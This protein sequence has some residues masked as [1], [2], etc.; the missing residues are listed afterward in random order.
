MTDALPGR[1]SQQVAARLLPWLLLL[2][3]LASLAHF[4]HNAE[5]L[6]D[7]PNLPRSWSP[8]EVY[9]AW[10]AVSAVG[11]GGYLMYR[12]RQRRAGLVLLAVYA[13]LGFAGLAHYQRAPFHRHTA[14]MNLTIL[15]EVAAALVLLMDVGWLLRRAR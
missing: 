8:A 6:A 4:A 12:G 10:C 5:Y 3:A 11:L 1:P 15:I 14:L 7:Y 2:Y 9:L 13:C